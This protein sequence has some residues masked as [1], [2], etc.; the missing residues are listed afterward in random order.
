MKKRYAAGFDKAV[1][2]VFNQHSE[3]DDR[4]RINAARFAAFKTFDLQKQLFADREKYADFNAFKKIAAARIAQYNAFQKTEYNTLVARC[5][6]AK[7]FLQFQ[8]DADIYPN[9][10]WIATRSVSP[11]AE[12]VQYTGLILPID[13]PFWNS[14]QPGN[15]YNCKCDWRR[16][17]KDPTAKPEKTYPPA[18]GLDGNPA[19][20]GELITEQHPYFER[21]ADAPKWVDKTALLQLPDEVA[22]VD[23]TAKNGK[24]YLEH[25]LVDREHE[26]KDNRLMSETLLNNGYTDIKLLPQISAVDRELRERY[27]GKNFMSHSK[28]PDA[29]VN[30]TAIEFKS[31]TLRNMSKHI[32]DAAQKSHIAFLRVK[33]SM[34]ENNILRFINGQWNMKDRE[35]LREIILHVNGELRI[36]RRP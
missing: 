18:R 10:E 12:H 21:N 26:A 35:N 9:I 24:K 31:S 34:P 28:C 33:E 14:N 2:L 20:T 29:S 17:S 36:F 6:S 5:R 23:K 11:R 4:L 25:R 15:E 30:G 16:T 8:E 1:T 13:D 7:Q 27:Y 32:L 22:F 19:Q 3:L